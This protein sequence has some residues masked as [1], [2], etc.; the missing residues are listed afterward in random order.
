MSRSRSSAGPGNLFHHN[1]YTAA[2]GITFEYNRYGPLLAGAGGNNL[3]DRSAGMV[4]RYNWIEGGNR[5]L[6]LV[7]AEDS[8]QPT[9]SIW[10]GARRGSAKWTGHS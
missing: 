5:Q 9:A 1:S 2:I 7:D 4:A 3:K 6:D 10:N 8:S